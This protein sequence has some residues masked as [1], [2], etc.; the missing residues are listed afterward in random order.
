MPMFIYEKGL[1]VIQDAS[2]FLYQNASRVQNAAAAREFD[3]RH[4]SATTL[5]Y[6]NFQSI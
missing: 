5:N 2:D 3:Q 6:D 4:S 1:E